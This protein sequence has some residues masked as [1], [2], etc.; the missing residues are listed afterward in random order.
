MMRVDVAAPLIG[1]PDAAARRADRAPTG[2]VRSRDATDHAR[3]RDR[4]PARCRAGGARP[5]DARGR[6]GGPP[7]VARRTSSQMTAE[8]DEASRVVGCWRR[9]RRLAAHRIHSRGQRISGKREQYSLGLGVAHI[10]SLDISGELR[11][12]REMSSYAMW[13]RPSVPR[14]ALGCVSTVAA[15]PVDCGSSSVCATPA[16]GLDIPETVTRAAKRMASGHLR[17]PDTP[18]TGS[19]VICAPLLIYGSHPTSPCRSG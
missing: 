8:P 11:R 1:H 16:L 17:R 15:S 13:R 7:S 9:P 19:P 5:R 4:L 18:A 3:E 6:R 14:T 12:V 10:D 2:P